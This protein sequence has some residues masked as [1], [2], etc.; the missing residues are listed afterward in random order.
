MDSTPHSDAA[1]TAED[2]LLVDALLDNTPDH[3]YFKDMDSRFIRSSQAQAVRFGLKDPSEAVGKTDFDF[4]SAEHARQAFEDEQWILR[5]GQSIIGKEERETW[6]DGRVTWVS[7]TKMPLRDKVGR[8][9]GTFGISRDITGRKLAEERAARYADE[10]RMRNAQ[11][12]ADLVMAREMQE[13][14]LPHQF[15]RFPMS[16]PSHESALQFFH[17]YRPSSTV[18]GDF[19]HVLPLSASE[20]GVFICD[21]MG[22][23][24]RA[25]LVTAMVRA[26]VEELAPIADEPGRYL[27]GINRGLMSTLRQTQS[28]I[29]ASAFYLVADVAR[30]GLRYANAGH[31]AP[32]HMR[33]DRRAVESLSVNGGRNGPVLGVF[34]DSEYVTA[35]RE[36]SAHDLVV[37]YTDGV[38]EVD[39]P[40]EQQFGQDRLL[41]AVRRRMQLPPDRLFDE[42][43]GELRA[44]SGKEE[45][46]DDVCLVGV[47][48][49]HVGATAPT[50]NAR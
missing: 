31:P 19:F 4:F 14:L 42:L 5:T 16:A 24:V 8:I 29:F 1:Q 33:R 38:F 21:V 6:P 7:T 45:F 3:I 41:D 11:M 18:G 35:N 15:P 47:E 28:P 2:R 40:D 32:F 44:F 12:E 27:A 22:K 37:L 50:R 34:D 10:L 13:A 36:L 39:G 23:G 20:A 43:L 30:G 49:T 9:I 17:H 25:A 46:V 26:L 48:A